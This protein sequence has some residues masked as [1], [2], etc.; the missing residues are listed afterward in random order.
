MTMLYPR[1]LPS[2]TSLLFDALKCRSLEEIE[3]TSELRSDRAIFAA[4]GGTR[5]TPD[6]LGSLRAAIARSA[7]SVGYPT[8]PGPRARTDFDVATARI[9]AEQSGMVLGEAAQPQVWAFLAL[10]VMPHICAWRF[11]PRADGSYV[12]DRFKGSDLTRHTLGRLW[13]RAHVL[14][15]PDAAGDAFRLLAV[16]GEADIDQVMARRDSVAASPAL[17]R[18]IVRTHLDSLPADSVMPT[19]KVLRETLVR[20]L[21]LLAFLDVDGYKEN[22]LDELVKDIRSQSLRDLQ[23][24]LNE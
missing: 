22:E 4:S 23:L 2:E 16:L 21:R 6:H 8:A 20:L 12:A 11:P 14:R 9:L 3:S 15:E 13:T 24:A 18:A 10:V 19:R 5:V 17:V 1:L 7:E